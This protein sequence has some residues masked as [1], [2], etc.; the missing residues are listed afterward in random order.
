[1]EK[2]MMDKKYEA[3]EDARTLIR[4]EEVKSN[5]ARRKAAFNELKK[6]KSNIDSVQV[7][8]KGEK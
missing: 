8:Q 7:T 3:E 2:S 4:A 1:M 5:S 6:Q